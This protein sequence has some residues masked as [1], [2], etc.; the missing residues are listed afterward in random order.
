MASAMKWVRLDH[1][2][3]EPVSVGDMVSADA[4][5]MPIFQVIRFEDGQVWLGGDH[6]QTVLV[7]PLEAFQW[8]AHLG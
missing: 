7:Q 3:S 5:G 2:D 1:A 8:K 6:R 4:G